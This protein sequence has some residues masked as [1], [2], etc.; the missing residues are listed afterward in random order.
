MST[1]TTLSHWRG[2]GWT[3]SKPQPLHSA[4][5][6]VK[7]TLGAA[8][9]FARNWQAFL[10]TQKRPTRQWV[11]V[12]PEHELVERLAA[13]WSKRS[14]TALFEEGAAYA[15]Q[16]I[17]ERGGAMQAPDERVR[18]RWAR[19]ESALAARLPSTLPKVN[20]DLFAK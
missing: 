9:W 11:R 13:Y 4:C 19:S 2:A 15:L 14:V 17:E 12:A 10:R 5:S 16:A 6:Q 1:W 18:G 3:S 8:E 20:G 7:G